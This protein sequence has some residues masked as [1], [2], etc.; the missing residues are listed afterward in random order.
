M[1][2]LRMILL[3]LCLVCFSLPLQA[4]AAEP[5]ADTTRTYSLD[6]LQW[7]IVDPNGN[8]VSSSKQRLPIGESTIKSG[9]TMYFYQS[10]GS[11]IYLNK[12]D[13]MSVNIKFNKYATVSAGVKNTGTGTVTTKKSKGNRDSVFFT[14]HAT[15]GSENLRAWVT[16][17]TADS[18]NVTGGEINIG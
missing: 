16:N 4:F 1:K 10:D 5:N 17:H 13:A 11:D 12:G 3:M 14:Y 15:N 6:E 7:E 2:R 8:V 18:I 9:Y